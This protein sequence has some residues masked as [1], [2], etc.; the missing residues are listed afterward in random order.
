MLFKKGQHA[1][2]MTEFKKGSKRTEGWK[3]YISEKFKRNRFGENNPNWKDGR[4]YDRKKY[5]EKLAGRKMPEQCEIC[6]AFGKEF[7]K[8]IV[9]DHDHETGKFRGWICPRCNMA[10]GLVKENTETLEA[11]IKYIKS[12]D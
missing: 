4:S 1:S 7:Q 3:K 8:G 2:L 6:G 11:I 5:L 9:F 12:F 10:I